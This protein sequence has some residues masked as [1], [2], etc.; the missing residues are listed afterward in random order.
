[1]GLKSKLMNTLR[2]VMGYGGGMG[3]GKVSFPTRLE[4]RH[5]VPD[6]NGE[7]LRP[8]MDGTMGRFSE[9]EKD[10]RVELDRV[11][12]DAYVDF[13]VD[14]HQT[15][16]SIFGDFKYHEMGLGTQTENA[17]ETALQTTTGISRV[18]GT[19]TEGSSSNIY[20]SVGTV[21]A[22]AT[23]A[24]TEHG[25]FNASTGVTMMDRTKFSAINVVS[26]NQIEFTF[27]ITFSSGG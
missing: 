26:G 6:E 7:H 19:Q 20:Q 1:M 4:I 16:T 17:N 25:L 3:G 13:I 21:T 8:L 2:N 11:V 5:F 15:E 18:V 12:T 22:D 14:Q 24:I 10:Y 27:E 23:E 9:V